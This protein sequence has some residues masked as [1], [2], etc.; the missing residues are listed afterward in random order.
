MRRKNSLTLKKNSSTCKILLFITVM[1]FLNIFFISLNNSIE[2]QQLYVYSVDEIYENETLIVSVYTLDE[3]ISPVFLSDVEIEFNGERYYIGNNTVEVQILTPPVD[4]D[5]VF[6]VNASKT[7]FI[8]YSKPILIKN[9]IETVNSE[10]E[11]IVKP[12]SD[13]V[14]SSALFS[15]TVTFIGVDGKEYPV[16]GAKVAVQS[17]GEF[18]FTDE[19]GKVRL[20]APSD[21]WDSDTF[22]VIANK[23]GYKDGRI[24]VGLNK[25]VGLFES[26]IQNPY[27]PIFMATL[28]LIIIILFVHFRQ[29]KEIYNRAREISDEKTLKKYSKV[30]EIPLSHDD[31][32]DVERMLSSEE[33]V[34]VKSDQDAKVEEI[35]L[36]RSR[37]EKE[38]VPIKEEDET[39]KIILRKK[40]QQR[41]YD[42]FEGIDEIRYEIDK[43]TGKIDENGVDKWF[44]GVE[45]IKEKLD[46]KMKK[47][48]VL[49]CF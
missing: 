7:G 40:M 21:S 19:F 4:E 16:E 23:T 30:E 3:N 9:K 34:K 6:Y 47:K 36:I 42:W 31:K 8:S 43:L 27:F 28:C 18:K 49:G 29:E 25:E 33:S 44:E 48:K 13:P 46:E 15:V 17:Y 12:S 14:D 26:I 5:T 11:L 20:T 2:E 24:S 10:P 37:K 38:V 35:R 39:D 41:D 32:N 45:D 1:L 22:T